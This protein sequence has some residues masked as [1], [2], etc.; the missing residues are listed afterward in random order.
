MTTHRTPLFVRL[1]RDQAAA[2]DRL[3]DATGRAKQH[4]ISEL[5]VERLAPRGRPL[6]IG[7]VEVT[8]TADTRNDEVLTLDETAALLKLPVDTVRT[9][10]E[11][12][13]LPGR[14]FGNEWRFARTAVIAWLG[15]G[16]PH[17]PERLNES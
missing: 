11:D 5:L 10:A 3:A 15:S 14:R 17:N 13:D 9:R 8:N 2:L 12:G 16:E 7:R 4:L 1:P 6:S